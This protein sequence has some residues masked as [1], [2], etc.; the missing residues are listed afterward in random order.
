MKKMKKNIIYLLVTC[1]ACFTAVSCGDDD[2]MDPVGNWDLTSPVIIE[3]SVSEIVLSEDVSSEEFLF[4]WQPAVSS[5]GYQIR[6]SVVL[7]TLGSTDYD[8]PILK[9][10]SDN[11]G[12]G[13]SVSISATAID[14]ALSYA[15]YAAGENAVVEWAVVA[16]CL[17][18][19]ATDVAG[20]TFK[21]FE[22]EYLPTT[23]Y[24]SGTATENGSELANAIPL[25]AL[26]NAD[27]ELTYEFETYTTL[28]AGGNFKFYS[29][30]S[31]PAHIYGGGNGTVVKSGSPITVQ[32]TAVY[33]IKV[34]LLNN[35]YSLLEIEKWSI[36]GGV[37]PGGWG[38]DEPLTYIGGGKWQ[39]DFSL[40]PGGFVFRA[41]GNWG[42][43]LKRI[44]GTANALYMEAES[45]AAGI[46][47]EDI[48]L[49][50]GGNYTVTLNLS[51]A[52]YTYT[53]E[54]EDSGVEPPSSIPDALYLL[55]N[56]GVVVTFNNDGSGVFTTPHY[57]ALQASVAYQ[58]N[59]SEDGSGTSYV[60][61]S[62]LGET[63]TPNTDAVFGNINF[64]EGAS[65]IQVVTDQMYT[66]SF[67][68]NTGGASWKYYNLKLFHWDEVGG[69]WDSR[70]EF[71][72]TYVHPYKFTTTQSLQAGYHMKFN[73][74]W[75]IQFG[76]DN[77]SAMSGT[78]TNNGGSNFNNIT[79]S[80][81]Y[82]ANIEV[83]NTYATGTYQFISQ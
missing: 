13:L 41:N 11:V 28:N 61:T 55:G 18:R 2:N 32:E 16:E 10:Q 40:N 34:D 64:G 1:V 5:A 39:G 20:I 3:P 47:I 52:P 38:G 4:S 59:S 78:M 30:P 27:G 37:I 81:T 67:N 80:G 33:R 6:Y 56:G 66:M 44:Q 58:L 50:E 17:D 31:L 62:A 23:L 51:S 75:D 65:S 77:P 69:G 26:T 42:Y 12:R 25:R 9:V 82:Q 73:S 83:V 45:G 74:P 57:V 35:T 48:P 54:I 63:D 68:F 21:R 71:P 53:M 8:T 76:A 19:Q 60:I 14:L 24:L 36:V 15:G 46:S 49:D 72:M 22:T 29:Q 79:S 7:D 43:L 70:N